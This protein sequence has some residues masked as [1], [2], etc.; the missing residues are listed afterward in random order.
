[1]RLPLLAMMLGTTG[2]DVVF[3]ISDSKSDAGASDAVV[4]DACARAADFGAPIIL[5][6][7]GG[8][9]YNSAPQLSSDLLEIYVTS[10][11]PGGDWDLYRATRPAANL[12][13][14]LLE[15]M[16]GFNTSDSEGEPAITADGLTF[17]FTRQS[18]AGAVRAFEARRATSTAP[19]SNPTT[20]LGLT[21][22]NTLSLD[23]SPDGL[24]VYYHSGASGSPLM[25]TKRASLTMPFTAP[26]MI[27]PEAWFPSVSADGL[28]LYFQEKDITPNVWRATRGAIGAMFDTGT[29]YEAD[30]EDADVSPDGGALVTRIGT[31]LRLRERG[32]AP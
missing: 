8:A 15:P 23:L 16:L 24:T 30:G 31:S 5:G 4:S 9:L 12:P 10:E 26:V 18:S 14:G 17:M 1:M 13:F 22:T 6:P 29:P 11:G 32:C 20:P 21:A 7:L 27:G 3:G 28:E 2:C 25:A 19:W